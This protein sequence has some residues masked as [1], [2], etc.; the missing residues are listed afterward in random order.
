MIN[1]PFDVDPIRLF[2][3]YMKVT[4]VP[5]TADEKGPDPKLA[6]KKL[7]LVNGASWI[8][9]WGNYFG[10]SI[11][12]GVKMVN[13]GNEG[14][15]LNFM[16]AHHLNEPCPPQINIDLFC[17]YARDMFDLVGVDAIMITCSTMNR[18][19][20]QVSAAMQE[21]GVPTVQID[22]PMME[23][24]V[25]TEGKIL[26]VATHG[27]TVKST[28]SLLQET[29]N[30]LGR[31]VSF[32][33]ITVEQAFDDL[34]AGRIAGHNKV[35]ADAIRESMSKEK[36]DIVV[37]AQLSMAVFAFSHPD[38]LADFGVKVLNGAETGFRRAGEVL[39]QK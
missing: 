32:S 13:V 25:N 37:L 15:Q 27:P 5:T 11:L 6:G 2:S 34:G 12:P 36:I 28:Q 9:L 19:Y 22:M 1:D 10:K 20:G 17:K 16:R 33:G 24:A 14:V 26:V 8:A 29:A 18:S 31:K 39:R 30:R 38:P 23:E 4:G 7:G 3:D 21:V 35:V